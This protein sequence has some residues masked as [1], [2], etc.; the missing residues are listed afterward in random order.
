MQGNPTTQPMLSMLIFPNLGE[1]CPTAPMV[2]GVSGVG[3]G[4]SELLQTGYTKP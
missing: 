2:V 3:Q 1:G 4:D